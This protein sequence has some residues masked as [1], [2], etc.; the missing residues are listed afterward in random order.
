MARAS[1]MKTRSP[2][3]GTATAR[4]WFDCPCCPPN[5][6]RT[7]AS[8]GKYFYSTGPGSLWVHLFGREQRH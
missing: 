8:M 7:M 6:A 5:V 1:S 4:A 2:A 3:A